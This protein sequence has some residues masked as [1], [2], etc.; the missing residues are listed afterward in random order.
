MDRLV[1]LCRAAAAAGTG[2]TIDAEESER[3]PL[4]LELFE[5]LAGHPELSGWHGLGI[6]VQAY[7]TAI[8]AMVQ[9]ILVLARWRVERGGASVN[10]RLVKGAYWDAEIKRAQEIGSDGY[11]VFADKRAT[12]LA[13]LAAARQLLDGAGAVFTQFATH[14]PVTL[15]CVLALAGERPFECQRL[16][17]MGE[18]LERGLQHL[19]PAIPM[20][21]YAPVGPRD[22]LLAY[23]VRRLLENGASTS[24][25]RQAARAADPQALLAAGFDFLSKPDSAPALPLPTELHMPERRVAKGYDLAHPDPLAAFAAS[26]ARSRGPW[27]AAPLLGGRREHGTARQVFSPADSETRIGEV[28][29][30]T[31]AVVHAALARA[32]GARFAWAD[33][34]VEARAAVL[35]RLAGRLEADI[36]NLVALCVREA[37]K[38]LADA[39]ADVREA[40]DF[41]RYYAQ[42]ARATLAQP[43][44][45]RGPT[46]ESNVLTL[47]GRGV[48]ACISPW[49][50]PVAI[51]TGQVAAALVAGNTVVAKPAEQTS[52]AA[53]RVAEL[54]LEAGVPPDAFHLLPGDG[55]VGRLLVEDPR[56]AGVVF[57]GSMDTARSI[58]RAL[59]MREGPIAPLIAET[60]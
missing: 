15:A 46:G 11:P 28:V 6:A 36:E 29:D 49:N 33:T 56:V 35:D 12:D 53:H 27:A 14:N 44:A 31:A 18:A 34:G 13:Y 41:C 52:L 16:H 26:T 25:V 60:G 5:E 22:D 38:T 9:R 2:L 8:L 59:A 55:A 21:V 40:V 39:V 17:G 50:F 51:F 32:H 19:M 54:L 23:L 58:H 45:L 4:H 48:F 7:S 57:T 20:R 47:H 24:F 30:A 43:V 37:G 3:L 42:Q 10:V 1:G